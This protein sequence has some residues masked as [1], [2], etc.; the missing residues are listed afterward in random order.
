MSQS[1]LPLLAQNQGF[2]QVRGQVAKALLERAGGNGPERPQLSQ[3]GIADMIGS[4]WG[5]VH[6]SLKSLEEKGAIKMERNRI[7]VNKKSLQKIARTNAGP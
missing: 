5:M 3:R 4:N 2:N 7:F 6:M 1:Y